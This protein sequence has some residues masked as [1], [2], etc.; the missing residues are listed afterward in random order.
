MG[1]KKKNKGKQKQVRKPVAKQ[2]PLQTIDEEENLRMLANIATMTNEFQVETQNTE[3]M[4]QTQQPIE[5][6]IPDDWEVVADQ[7]TELEERTVWEE[8]ERVQAENS[9]QPMGRSRTETWDDDV[10]TFYE[11]QTWRNLVV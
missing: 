4:A 9:R 6:E 7:I 2:T 5:N 11:K 3:M 10:L 1:K 8:I